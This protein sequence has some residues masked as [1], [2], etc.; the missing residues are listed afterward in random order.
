MSTVFDKTVKSSLFAG[1]LGGL[2]GLGGGVVLT[3]LWLDMGI[4]SARATASATFS[5]FFTATIAVFIIGLS[6]GYT[7]EEFLI[8]GVMNHYILIR[9]SLERAVI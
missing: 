2:V 6:G 9:E 8:L 3:P 5:V 1:F 4:A 7:L